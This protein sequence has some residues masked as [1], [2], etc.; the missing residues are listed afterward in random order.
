MD[1]DVKR[2]LKRIKVE[3]DIILTQE[4]IKVPFH[5]KD[6]ESKQINW[7]TEWS[8]FA[9]HMGIFLY[10]LQATNNVLKIPDG[11]NV[12]DMGAFRDSIRLALSN[13]E[14]GK[15]AIDELIALSKYFEKDIK[16]MKKTFSID[17]WIT[18]FLYIYI[19]NILGVKKNTRVALELI[20]AV[21]L[22]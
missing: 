1:I 5:G 16:W 15:R 19:Y 10:Y 7:W 17:D 22:V 2:I 8:K 20:K 13:I 4:S 21:T 18:L 14:Y 12:E 9:N 3:D 6:I 11:A